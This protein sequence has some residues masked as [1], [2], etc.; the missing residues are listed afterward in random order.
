[1][2]RRRNQMTCV[3]S[4]RSA[5]VLIPAR[6]PRSNQSAVAAVPQA[7]RSTRS[8][9]L[10]VS[11]VARALSGGTRLKMSAGTAHKSVPSLDPNSTRTAQTVGV[12]G[13]ACQ[14]WG[15]R[16][17]GCATAEQVVHCVVCPLQLEH[18]AICNSAHS[19]LAGARGERHSGR[20][21]LVSP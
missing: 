19:N 10:S 14:Y 21:S 11:T 3:S 17:M 16:A 2:H 1:L 12:N 5:A 18:N 6:Q 20:G 13:V 4:D 8:T 9:S 7:S 15:W